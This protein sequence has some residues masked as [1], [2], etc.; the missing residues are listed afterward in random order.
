MSLVD[1]WSD[2]DALLL[3]REA[4]MPPLCCCDCVLPWCAALP[5]FSLMPSLLVAWLPVA[6]LPVA[7]LPVAWLPVA[8][9][10]AL[11]AKD[12]LC[13]Y[14]LS[15]PLPLPLPEPCLLLDWNGP[16]SGWCWPELDEV[17][18]EL[19]SLSLSLAL[20]LPFSLAVRRCPLLSWSTLLAGRSGRS[21]WSMRAPG[22]E[23]L[24]SLEEE[25]L[26]R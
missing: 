2:P 15:V 6:W 19:A 25:C 9:L 24:E 7:W 20:G 8:W 26:A 18:A 16:L 14:P 23:G 11:V 3:E 1:K 21:K 17:E 5:V 13:P 12:T 4:P 22:P 10:P